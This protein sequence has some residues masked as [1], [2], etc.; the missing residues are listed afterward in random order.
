MLKGIDI[1]HWQDGID[2]S[3]LKD[4]DFVICKATEGVGYTDK[5]CD[6][7][8]QEAKRLGKKVGVYHFA[9]P[10]LGNSAEKEA[11]YFLKE[12]EGYH[13]EAILILDWEPYKGKIAD[14]KWAKAWLDR[15]YEKTGIRAMIYMS[16]SPMRVYNW[17]E[18]AEN[19][20]LWVANYGINN[21]QPNANVFDNYPIA[22][23]KSAT[24]WQYTSKGR[25]EGY[26]GNLDLNNFYGDATTWDKIANATKKEEPE[27]PKEEP[28]K[29]IDELVDEIIDGKWGNGEERKQKLMEAGYNYREVQDKV[30]EKLKEEETIKYVVQKGDTLTR[31]ARKYD[32]TIDK[33]VKD[34]NIK[35]ADKIYVGQVLVIK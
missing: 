12:T 2:I 26:N 20:S 34:N 35:D 1:S 4:V 30:N 19:Y 6:G 22:H 25:I 18:V 15:V 14:V 32:T 10:D 17:D 16:A 11:D 3:K 13:N 21:G 7:F 8:Y 27:K 9:R 23:W 5:S 31:I 33:I 28:K 29:S 24:M